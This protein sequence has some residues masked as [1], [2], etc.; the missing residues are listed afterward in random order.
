MLSPLDLHQ[1][2]AATA[3]LQW[4]AVCGEILRGLT[5]ALSNRIGLLTIGSTQLATDTSDIEEAVA[6]LRDECTTFTSLLRLIRLLPP[7][8]LNDASPAEPFSFGEC[9]EEVVAI[10]RHHRIGRDAE[11]RVTGTD[12][13]PAIW[14]RR[15]ELRRALITL[16]FAAL[17]DAAPRP[18]ARHRDARRPGENAAGAGKAIELSFRADPHAVT[19]EI[20][21]P[22]SAAESRRA[23]WSTAAYFSR[24]A[25]AELR[26]VSGSQEA[27]GDGEDASGAQEWPGTIE[28]WIPTLA[29]VKAA[30]RPA[31]R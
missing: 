26:S 23:F 15:I 22:Q 27:P 6:V 16:L 24:A 1:E 2:G 11:V 21:A 5:H 14:A 29:A 17:R 18:D 10:V 20:R 30:S 8:D 13:L 9:V 7:H 19:L 25:G 3:T 31:R 28:L 4:P 12:G